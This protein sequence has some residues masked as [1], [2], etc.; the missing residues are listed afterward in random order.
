MSDAPVALYIA[1]YS[2]AE[3]VRQDWDDIKQ[4]AREETTRSRGCCR[5]PSGGRR[6]RRERQGDRSRKGTVIGAVGGYSSA[7]S[8]RRRSWP[9]ASSAPESVPAQERSSTTTTRKGSTRTSKP[10]YR[11]AAGRSS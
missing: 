9:R 4:L 2:D 11:P 7:S 10:C 3:V 5:Q 8:S 1:T 6:D